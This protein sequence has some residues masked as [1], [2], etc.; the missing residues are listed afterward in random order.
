MGLFLCWRHRTWHE[1]GNPFPVL[2]RDLPAVFSCCVVRIYQGITHCL[3]KTEMMWLMCVSHIFQPALAVLLLRSE[4]FG[5]KI[6]YEYGSRWD[7]RI[8]LSS[9]AMNVPVTPVSRR[10][11]CWFQ[12]FL[13]LFQWISLISCW[14]VVHCTVL[15]N[16]IEV[17]N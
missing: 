8:S 1:R 7:S 17:F 15:V 12:I 16:V 3:T 4:R 2:K 5:G 14:N 11:N 6:F 13:L 10:W 9:S